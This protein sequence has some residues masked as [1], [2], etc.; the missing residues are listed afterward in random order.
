MYL[1][2]TYN[3]VELPIQRRLARKRT[4]VYSNDPVT[5]TAAALSA[6]VPASIPYKHRISISY[7]IF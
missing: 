6:C 1:K 5:D 2:I 4:P 3:N 7:D